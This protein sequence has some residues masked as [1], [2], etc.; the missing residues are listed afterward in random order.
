V[1]LAQ[2]PDLAGVGTGAALVLVIAYLLRANHTDRTQHREVVEALRTQHATETAELTKRIDRLDKRA[3][4]LEAEVDQERRERRAAEDVA[5]A[6]DRRAIAAEAR[7][8]M[9]AT[10]L[11][12]R[13][14]GDDPATTVRLPPAHPPDGANTSGAARGG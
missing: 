14:H 8:D 2:L 6:A 11:E 1:D 13:A 3:D 9:L 10:L 12:G 4:E 7:A 5:A